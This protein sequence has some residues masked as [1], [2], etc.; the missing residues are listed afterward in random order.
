MKPNLVYADNVIAPLRF[1]YC[2]MCTSPLAREVIFDDNIPRVRCPNCDW[3]QLSSNVVGVTV[4]A[5]NETG[6]AAILPP[7]EDG[8]G[9]PGG[10]VEYGEDPE[11]AAVREVLE[12]TGLEVEIVD[13]LGWYF[14]NCTTWPGPLVQFM[15]EA[16]IVGGQ[17]KGS[18]EGEAKV[19]AEAALPP[20]S[21]RRAGSQRARQAYFLKR[22]GVSLR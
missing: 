6:I 2:P 4:I 10:L 13:C 19:F 5:Q 16:K 8:I 3:I 18:S 12:E 22:N 17:V 15:Y 9:F 1:Q 21:S 7:G 20:I 11:S 14:A